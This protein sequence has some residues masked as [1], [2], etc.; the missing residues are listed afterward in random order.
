MKDKSSVFFLAQTLYAL[1]KMTHQSQISG[2]LSGWVKIHKIH[3]VIFEIT[4]QLFFK[5]WI[6]LQSHER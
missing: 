2:L 4:S 6:T 1:A 5:P 3:H